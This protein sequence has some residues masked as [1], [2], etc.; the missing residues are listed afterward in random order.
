MAFEACPPSL[1]F[2]GLLHEKS[3]TRDQHS[4]STPATQAFSNSVI[5]GCHVGIDMEPKHT[6]SLIRKE[7]ADTTWE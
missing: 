2:L 3:V 1:M 4:L 5:C 6:Q 7:V